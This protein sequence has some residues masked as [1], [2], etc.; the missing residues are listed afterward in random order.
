MRPSSSGTAWTTQWHS[1]SP[2]NGPTWRR[3]VRRLRRRYGGTSSKWKTSPL[4]GPGCG[5][6]VGRKQTQ[7]GSSEAAQLG[8]L[9]VSLV[10]I[11]LFVWLCEGFRMPA[12]DGGAAYTG[13]RRAKTSKGGN[14]YGEGRVGGSGA[15][16]H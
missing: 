6:R 16:R 5:N 15:T 9:I 13:G 2:R 10:S 12:H 11:D 3:S 14:R 1:T 7:I 8:G 4:P